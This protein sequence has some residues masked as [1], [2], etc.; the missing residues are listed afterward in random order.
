MEKKTMEGSFPKSVS[1]AEKLKKL[2][3]TVSADD[4]VAILINADPDAMASAFA[5]KR[6]FWRRVK[7]VD[8]VR[9][10][11]IERTDNLA[12]VR[13]IDLT[14]RHI[15]N[16][17]QSE[18][19]KWAL[20]DSQP[21]H[22][23][24]FGRHDFDIIIDHHPV[25]MPLKAPFIDIREQYGANST[26]LCEY[27]RTAKIKPSARLATAL[28]YGIKTDTD[29]FVRN[30]ISRDIKA[31]RYLY[32]FANINII[33]KIE[34]SE[35]AKKNIPDF[36][37]ALENLTFVHHTAFIHMGK[38]ANADTL[39]MLADFFMKMAEATWSIV[40]GVLDKKL[41]VIYRNAGFRRNAGKL[42]KLMFGDTGSAGGHKSMA[43][44]EIPIRD[45]GLKSKK[46]ADVA[47]YV[48]TR[49]KQARQDL[50]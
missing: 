21:D 4:I 14:Q 19:S 48:L 11:K 6:L 2:F 23:A 20:L 35:I 38:V 39:V 34:S 27:L 3:E 46:Q 45:L 1:S 12:F 25:T 40:S 13:I 29:N 42:A 47:Q 33:K 31:F 8:I 41:V 49:I 30:T 22:D 17:K 5:L 24:Q 26:I 18:A 44:A 16:Y 28:F 50:I 9:I 37:A 15:R 7:R 10:N 32:E 43:R 36:K